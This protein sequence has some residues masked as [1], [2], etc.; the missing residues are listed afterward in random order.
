MKSGIEYMTFLADWYTE[1]SKKELVSSRLAAEL[2][3]IPNLC[4]ADVVSGY[5]TYR[6]PFSGVISARSVIP[7]PATEAIRE[8]F[9]TKNHLG[10]IGHPYTQIHH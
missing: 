9:P 4:R 7:Q 8:Q 2:R 1:N 6:H 10:Q 5:G 3:A